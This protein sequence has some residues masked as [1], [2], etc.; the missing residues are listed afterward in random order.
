MI[1]THQIPTM[2]SDT[3]YFVYM[4]LCSDETIYTGLTNNVPKRLDT[5]NAGLGA[6]YTRS[7]RPVTLLAVWRC[8]NRSEASKLEMQFKAMP[9]ANKIALAKQQGTKILSEN[10]PDLDS[11]S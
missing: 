5:H 3:P 9:R 2:T 6:K 7:R 8:K 4:L 10:P 1:A 11:S